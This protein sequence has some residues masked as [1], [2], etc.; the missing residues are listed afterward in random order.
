MKILT[1][2]QEFM[3]YVDWNELDINEKRALLDAVSSPTNIDLG[4]F[5][6]VLIDKL[7]D[8]T[9]L[10]YP[11]SDIGLIIDLNSR[12]DFIHYIEHVYMHDEDYGSYLSWLETME[13]GKVPHTII[14]SLPTE[15]IV[16]L[17]NINLENSFLS[18]RV[19]YGRKPSELYKM[20]PL[21]K[22]K[23]DQLFFSYDEEEY[24]ADELDQAIKKELEK[25]F[26]NLFCQTSLIMFDAEIRN[27]KQ[28]SQQMNKATLH[29]RIEFIP[30]PF[31]SMI[32][33]QIYD[34][35]IYILFY[36]LSEEK[37]QRLRTDIVITTDDR[38]IFLHWKDLL[39][40][41]Y[42]PFSEII[43]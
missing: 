10:E 39:E 35:D 34:K 42:V 21:K 31:S 30:I 12:Q 14:A 2:F 16:F 41:T 27:I 23:N 1:N 22:T 18:C 38:E 7:E 8:R 40:N 33:P 15:R 28:W 20:N 3:S 43:K 32:Q 17:K 36:P 19:I 37:Q 11:L 25:K 29:V 9:R 4:L 5:R 26:A 13:N 6:A 24:P